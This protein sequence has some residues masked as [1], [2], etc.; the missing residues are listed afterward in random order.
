[1]IKRI[2]I[3]ALVAGLVLSPQLASAANAR[4]A[5]AASAGGTTCRDFLSLP[6]SGR[7]AYVAKLTREAPAQTLSVSPST[8]RLDSDGQ[9]VP[10]VTIDQ[11]P[12]LSAGLL[13]S[14]CGAAQPSSTLRDAYS[15][16][17]PG[18]GASPANF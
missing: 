13:V 15:Q 3:V 1:L 10:E 12:D 6:A 4:I 2:S 18:P 7:D 5:L 8:P 17:Y 16:S 11:E 9:I 14:T